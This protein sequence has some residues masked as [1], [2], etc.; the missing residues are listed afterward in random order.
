MMRRLLALFLTGFAF[1]GK[2]DSAPDSY[3][4]ITTEDGL[5]WAYKLNNAGDGAII[6]GRKKYEAVQNYPYNSYTY[7]FL[8]A[9]PS[10]SSNTVGAVV[11]PS[12]VAGRP[13]VGIGDYAFYN[14][15]KITA[16][17]Y[18]SNIVSISGITTFS[19]CTNLQEI[20][21]ANVGLL[22]SIGYDSYHSNPFSKVGNM[23]LYVNG[24]LTTEIQIPEGFTE[25]KKYVFYNWKRLS[26]VEIPTSV[27]KIDDCA[28]W[29]CEGL[30]NIT[31]PA[32]VTNIGYRA[33]CGCRITNL[34]IPASVINIGEDAFWGAWGS[35][36]LASFDFG[37]DL[38]SILY[39]PS[40]DSITISPG[41]KSI[42]SSFSAFKR[43]SKVII[44]AS[45]T[46]IST[47]AFVD[48]P[49]LR[50]EWTKTI[51]M[52]SANGVGLEAR[53]DLG[54]NTADRMVS[55]IEVDSDMA[56]DKFVLSN[57]KVY[58]CAIR[59]VNNASTAVNLTLPEGYVYES[60]VGAA[61]LVIP[62][63]S[64]NMLTITRTG[65]RTFL[66]SRRQLQP[67]GR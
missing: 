51:A 65:D 41:V 40:F 30:K 55:S 2:S 11:I 47:D 1:I 61:P 53:Y 44:P 67:I 3:Y 57:G 66:V 28:F 12:Y 64:T 38:S 36:E 22:A 54:S 31:I 14:C 16:L 32:S 9:T 37:R 63:K 27:T 43:L 10:I 45:V 58:D 23:D 20:H 50:T 35:L 39:A 6:V 48:C 56:I 4:T 17:T 60:F 18:P 34:T 62:P 52:L 21:V 26:K 13:V 29:G 7:K 15:N 59:I 33:F 24:V 49:R 19:N 46:N 5:N 42:P 25:I 8:Y